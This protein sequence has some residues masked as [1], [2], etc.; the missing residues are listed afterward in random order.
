MWDTT[1]ES[2]RAALEQSLLEFNA[3]QDDSL[4]NYWKKIIQR[5]YSTR[6]GI[7]VSGELISKDKPCTQSSISEWSVGN[8]IRSDAKNAVSGNINGLGKFH[9]ALEDQPWWEIDLE[10]VYE[11]TDIVIYNISDHLASRCKNIKIEF[12]N[13]GY[14]YNTLI[15]KKDF[16]PLG[17]ILT[18]PYHVHSVFHAR[19]IRII[20]LDYNFFHLDQVLIY[21]K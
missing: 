12:S 13:D 18:E 20:S 21:G 14:I 5:A 10:Q 15:E 11:I 6:V 17:S 8:D 4:T 1:E 3:V 9:T 7:P 2:Q 19:F 16:I